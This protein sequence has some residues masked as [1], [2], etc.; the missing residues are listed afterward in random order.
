MTAVGIIYSA[1]VFE[2]SQ[3]RTRSVGTSPL[4]LSD[5]G[6]TASPRDLIFE[7]GRPCGD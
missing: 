6:E 2:L 3:D 7:S 4:R 5:F 1:R